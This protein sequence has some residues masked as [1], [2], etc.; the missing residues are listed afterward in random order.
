M[1]VVTPEQEGIALDRLLRELLPGKSWN[2]ARKLVTSGKV[3]VDGQRVL[4]PTLRLRAGARVEL[5]MS[6]PKPR[7]GGA[8]DGS[9]IVHVDSQVV[10]VR[11]P[12]GISSVPYDENET[13]T[14]DELVRQLLK[15]PGSDAPLGVVHRLDKDT[16][17]L[18]V[19]ARTLTAKRAL[20]Q[21]FRFHTVQ[22]RYLAI[23]H[24]SPADQTFKSRLLRDR[25]DGRR[26]STNHSELGREAITHVKNLERLHGASLVECRLETGR[27][28]Q[29]RIHLSEAGHPV[30]GD[31]VYT[32][33]YRGTLLPAPRLM[34]HAFELGFEHPASG[35]LLRFEEPLPD[36]MKRVLEALRHG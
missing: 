10:V 4:E 12:A 32:H 28:H 8:L 25:G 19:F 29:I 5:R 1:H 23:V 16:S 13:G 31:K 14:L 17:G 22:R 2:D 36:D 3:S 34:L 33:G 35:Q 27:T 11:K 21:A 30:V 24:G 18:L 7:A 9:V 26:G 6:A 20:K 15:R